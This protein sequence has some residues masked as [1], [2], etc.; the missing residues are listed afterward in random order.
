MKCKH[1]VSELYRA[2]AIKLNDEA[3]IRKALI[4]AAE[5]AGATLIEI[6]THSFTPQGVT[7]FA[8]LAESHISIHT[9]P[10]FEFASVDA[11]TCGEATDPE[12]ACN[13]LASYLNAKG[14]SVSVIDRMSPQIL[15]KTYA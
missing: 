5:V 13:Y 3:L 9:W 6:V 7:G 1:C 14:H 8:L 2:D 12:L 15:N 10:E 4:N 11:F